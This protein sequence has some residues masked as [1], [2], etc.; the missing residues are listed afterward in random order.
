MYSHYSYLHCAAIDLTF[1]GVRTSAPCFIVWIISIYHQ[2]HAFLKTFLPNMLT[3]LYDPAI[4]AQN[5]HYLFA[6]V[7]RNVYDS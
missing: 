3:F 5:F 1:S 4:M 7:L 6:F 2:F